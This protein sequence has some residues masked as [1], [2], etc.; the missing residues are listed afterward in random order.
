M[1]RLLACTVAY[2]DPACTQRPWPAGI[3]VPSGTSLGWG[4]LHCNVCELDVSGKVLDAHSLYA[5]SSYATIK[6]GVNEM[7]FVRS[8]RGVGAF[9]AH[10]HVVETGED[11][12]DMGIIT[13]P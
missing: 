8:C 11:V 13:V 5:D 7:D 12:A 9:Q 1:R 2:A 3:E 10:P 6:L 4:G